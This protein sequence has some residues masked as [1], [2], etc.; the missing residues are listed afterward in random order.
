MATSL[1][2]NSDYLQLEDLI[3][4][5]RAFES[6]LNLVDEYFEIVNKE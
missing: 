2:L 4:V 6:N 5:I 3:F 1:L